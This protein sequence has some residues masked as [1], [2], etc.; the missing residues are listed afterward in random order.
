VFHEAIAKAL[1]LA[2]ARMRDIVL[3]SHDREMEHAECPVCLKATVEKDIALT[4]C[5][6][7][8]CAE[9]ILYVFAH[10]IQHE[11]TNGE[12]SKMPRGDQKN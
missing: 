4:P 11:R 8:F 2:Q 7:M 6:H 12:M 5:A 3:L 1:P 10:L 9:C